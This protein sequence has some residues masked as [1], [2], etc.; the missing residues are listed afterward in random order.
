MSKLYNM[1][2]ISQESFFFFKKRKPTPTI[3]IVIYSLQ[4]PYCEN[5]ENLPFF[6]APKRYLSFELYVTMCIINFCPA[7][8]LNNTSL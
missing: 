1:Q 2:I 7:Y 4:Y 6:G 3:F 8:S 5:E